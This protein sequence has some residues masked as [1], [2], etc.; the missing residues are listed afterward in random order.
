MERGC[1]LAVDRGPHGIPASRSP[2]VATRTLA[3]TVNMHA[4][5]SIA[6]HWPATLSPDQVMALAST[7]CR[8][9]RRNGRLVHCGQHA[10]QALQQ[11]GPSAEVLDA[12]VHRVR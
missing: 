1:A 11:A 12:L 2:A 9:Q 8:G 10:L 6:A 5:D 7:D 4:Y 3:I